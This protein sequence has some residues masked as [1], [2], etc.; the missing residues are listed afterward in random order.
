[1]QSDGFVCLVPE[2]GGD[3]IQLRRKSEQEVFSCS[4]ARRF[5]VNA[6][7][8]HS[9]LPNSRRKDKNKGHRTVLSPALWQPQ[10]GPGSLLPAAISPCKLL[11][12]CH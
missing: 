5:I 11:L 10:A 9:L 8:N 7:L 4:H 1:M 3:G 12:A 2:A 6:F